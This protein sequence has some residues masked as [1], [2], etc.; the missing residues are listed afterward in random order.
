MENPY[1]ADIDVDTVEGR[2][3]WNK[4]MT[5]LDAEDR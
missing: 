3:L 1:R 5:G 2:K 4:A